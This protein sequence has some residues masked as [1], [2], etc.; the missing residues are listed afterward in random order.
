VSQLITILIILFSTS[1]NRKSGVEVSFINDSEET[2]I[3]MKVKSYAKEYE[4]CNLRPGEKTKPVT[5][6]KT[7]WFIHTEVITQKDTVLFTG[8]CAVGETMIRDGKLVVSYGIR[9]KRGE[10]RRLY[11]SE[12]SYTGSAKNVGFPR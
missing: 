11:A 8:F 10:S 3:N 12:V 1:F 5:V 6:D 2:F 7:Y 9:P 4:F